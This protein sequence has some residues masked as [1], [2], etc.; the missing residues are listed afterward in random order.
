MM[1]GGHVVECDDLDEFGINFD[2]VALVFSNLDLY[3]LM[4]LPCVGPILLGNQR[5]LCWA[6]YFDLETYLLGNLCTWNRMHR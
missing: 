6:L 2:I 3:R 4:N 1:C 5:M